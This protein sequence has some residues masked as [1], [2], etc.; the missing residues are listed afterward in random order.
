[1]ITYL[2]LIPLGRGHADFAGED[3]GKDSRRGEAA[4][5]GDVLH[6]H[7]GMGFHE[8][9]SLLNTIV[10]DELVKIAAVLGIDELAEIGAVEWKNLSEIQ[11][12]EL[13]IK[14][15]FFFFFLLF[16]C[17]AVLSEVN[18]RSILLFLGFFGFLGVRFTGT[19]RGPGVIAV[20]N[21]L[22]AISD[23]Q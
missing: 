18:R 11:E 5:F 9:F 19:H 14:I 2:L 7:V 12:S 13:G 8:L 1:M 17:L 15:G 6:E 20:E 22:G 3:T 10:G 23:H 4:L 21:L 16:Q